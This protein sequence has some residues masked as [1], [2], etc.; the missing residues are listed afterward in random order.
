MNLFMEELRAAKLVAIIRGIAREDGEAA[1]DAMIAGG[2]RF[3]EITMNTDGAARLIHQIKTKHG[4]NVRVGA[5]TVLDQKMAKEALEAGAEYLVSPHFDHF[6]TDYALSKGV[7]VWPGALTPSEIHNAYAS[8][9]TAVKV[10]PAGFMGAGYIKN[11]RGPFHHIP[12]MVTG[13]INERNLR[14]FLKAGAFSAGIGGDVCDVEQIRAGNFH[15]IQ[16]RA[17]MYTKLVLEG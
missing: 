11:I 5:G 9:A 6:I 7:E 3:L 15:L 2:F 12:M 1:T 8:G 13:G 10:F 4:D 14:D 17:E 16:E